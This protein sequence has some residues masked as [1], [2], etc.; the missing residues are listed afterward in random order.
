M[1]NKLYKSQEC[2]PSNMN[3]GNPKGLPD[4]SFYDN[5]IVFIDD[6]FIAKLSKYFENS[7]LE[8]S[9]DKK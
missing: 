7:K 4:E 3:P 1:N 2:I 5:T 9:G 6:G 8:I